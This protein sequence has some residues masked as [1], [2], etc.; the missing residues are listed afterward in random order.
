MEEPGFVL[1]ASVT[2]SWAFRE[3][4]NAYTRTVLRSLKRVEALV[5]EI[6]P[7]E[8]GNALLVAER[9]NRVGFADI[10]RFLSFLQ[11]LP[12]VVEQTGPELIFGEVLLL[13]REQGLS[14][15]DAAYLDLAL[16]RG[17]PLATQDQKLKEAAARCGVEIFGGR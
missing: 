2:L 15:Y 9:R 12:I 1:D 17:L 10:T 3:E 8:V 4:L 6:W 14:V 7:L 5:P 13:A 16:R 11:E